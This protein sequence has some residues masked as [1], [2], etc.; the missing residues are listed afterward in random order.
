[1]GDIR[2]S[3]L[4]R[5]KDIDRP[6]VF[7]GW[8]RTL[9]TMMVTGLSRYMPVEGPLGVRMILRKAKNCGLNRGASLTGDSRAVLAKVLMVLRLRASLF[10]T[11]CRPY[12]TSRQ[13]SRWPGWQ[14]IIGIETHA[15][16][17]SREKLFSRGSE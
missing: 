14:V 15:Q 3:R 17:N 13:Y 7:S 1:M 16:I 4:S 5:L 12:S 10:R 6:T 8:H 2:A 11:S 9:V